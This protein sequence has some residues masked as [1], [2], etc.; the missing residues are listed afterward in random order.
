M[1]FNIITCTLNSSLTIR[2]CVESL[3]SQKLVQV[4]HII[5]DSA[6]IDGS[7]EY[8]KSIQSSDTYTCNLVS[9]PDQGIY[10]AINKAI[11]RTDKKCIVGFLHSDD[12][13]TKN[14]VLKNVEDIFIKTNCDIV[15]GGLSF[16][17]DTG[18]TRSWMPKQYEGINS[19]KNGWMPPHPTIFVKKEV[20]AKVGL[21]DKSFRISGDYEWV[22]RAFKQKNL[23]IK[24][25]NKKIYKMKLGGVSTNGFVSQ[26]IKFFE[27]VRALR[28]N[29]FKN[30]YFISIKKR[31]R[32]LF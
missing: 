24:L 6:S 21:Y 11:I 13:Y 12:F 17:N 16:F 4:K 19:L 15:F 3:K 7:L 5:Q 14:N 32:K 8:L 22:L 25:L 27:D 18:V 31:L 26:F 28:M 10:D 23:K 9:S 20:F 1:L 29:N 2:F 30:P